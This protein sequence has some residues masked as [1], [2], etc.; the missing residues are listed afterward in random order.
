MSSYLTG[1]NRTVSATGEIT[2]SFKYT[3]EKTWIGPIE[4]FSVT[5][6]A[7]P[8]PLSLS[9]H[10]GTITLDFQCAHEWP[11]SPTPVNNGGA[12]PRQFLVQAIIT[13]HG[14]YDLI[15]SPGTTWTEDIWLSV[16][17]P[18][19]IDFSGSFEFSLPCRGVVTHSSAGG[20]SQGYANYGGPAIADMPLYSSLEFWEQ[21]LKDATASVSLDIAIGSYSVTNTIPTTAQRADYALTHGCELISLGQVGRS[22][23]CTVTVESSVC[24]EDLSGS[25]SKSWSSA[26]GSG[27]VASGS[28]LSMRISGGAQTLIGGSTMAPPKRASIPI[29]LYAEKDTCQGIVRIRMDEAQNRMANASD[30][31][32]GTT[33]S[34]VQKY[35]IASSSWDG[36]ADPGMSIYEWTALRAWVDRQWLIDAGEDPDNWRILLHGTLFS[37]LTLN[38]YTPLEIDACGDIV[39]TGTDYDGAWENVANCTLDDVGYVHA[40]VSGGTGSFR[41]SFTD[42]TKLGG[43]RYLVIKIRRPPATASKTW[44]LRIGSKEWT[45]DWNGTLLEAHAANDGMAPE[46]VI[47]LCNPTNMSAPSDT[48]D[49]IWPTPTADS[50]SWGWGVQN[51]DAI[52][53]LGLED[54]TDYYVEYIGQKRM[55]AHAFGN[56]QPAFKW[57]A[58]E[59][60]GSGR[61]RFLLGDVDGK[62]SLEVTDTIIAAS[63]GQHFQRTIHEC[64][65]DIRDH[66]PGWRATITSAI[67]VADGLE[68]TSW[69][70]NWLNRQRPCTWL[71][72]AGLL[73]GTIGMEGGPSWHIGL[74]VYYETSQTVYAQVLCDRVDWYPGIGDVFGLGPAILPDPCPLYVAAGKQFRGRAWG[75]VLDTETAPDLPFVDARVSMTET[76]TQRDGGEDTTDVYGRYVTGSPYARSD[77]TY[78]VQLLT[79][80]EHPYADILLYARKS[81]RVCLRGA[82]ANADYRAIESDS[83]RAYM[84]VGR[85]IQIG[86]YH[87]QDWTLAMEGGDYLGDVITRLRV[88]TRYGLLAVLTRQDGSPNTFRVYTSADGGMSATLQLTQEARTAQI[89]ADSERGLLLVFY[90]NGSTIYRRSSDNAGVTWAA[91][92]AVT[93]IDPGR[94]MDMTCD[95][96][97]SS[98]YLAVIHNETDGAIYRSQDLGET[99]EPLPL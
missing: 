28:G 2:G 96:R 6:F 13:I 43:Y 78:R 84:Y 98:L 19:A 92:A 52:E 40:T 53:F 21:P 27:S 1:L 64:I 29:G 57:S 46:W 67:D 66:N 18:A 32:G 54:G 17:D 51:A 58:P 10:N 35:E 26:T 82:K 11:A 37:A 74:D 79:G 55:H 71:Y 95:A 75:I 88:D 12:H 81:H 85:D 97:W 14:M 31:A 42:P 36:T 73:Y 49:T 4:F 69:E 8:N 87:T 94:L 93:G 72:G 83:P 63:D 22:A 91:A 70:Y 33:K 34:L 56:W 20:S 44:Q 90:E 5:A 89:Q 77:K 65:D 60:D 76:V 15:G 41:R 48:F 68:Y 80:Q 30:V 47:D 24:G 25:Y 45:H 3:V 86:D 7:R 61:R 23:T 16:D 39:V 38:S 99:W 9:F 50:G 59:S 62:Q